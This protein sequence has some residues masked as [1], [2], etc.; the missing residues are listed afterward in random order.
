M[1]EYI[2]GYVKE[3]LGLPPF[4]PETDRPSKGSLG[5][6][7]SHAMQ[8]HSIPPSLLRAASFVVVGFVDMSQKR[9]LENG[10]GLGWCWPLPQKGLE[11]PWGGEPSRD[12]HGTV[13]WG[14]PLGFVQW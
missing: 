5:L 8:S 6:V 10:A 11:A 3:G 13:I 9:N 14:E 12:E 1:C 7:L 2:L 4:P